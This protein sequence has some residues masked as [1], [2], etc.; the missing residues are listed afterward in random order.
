MLLN[1]FD[2]FLWIALFI[3]F[4]LNAEILMIG[5]AL[6]T[7][8]TV[9]LNVTNNAENTTMFNYTFSHKDIIPIIA[10]SATNVVLIISV[11][12]FYCF[13]KRAPEMIQKSVWR[14]NN[15][16]NNDVVIV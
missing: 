16:S 9:Y 12:I 7:P 2:F 14:I 5:V 3:T 8:E 1:I 11:L 6:Q 4:V 10:Y 13:S 15:D